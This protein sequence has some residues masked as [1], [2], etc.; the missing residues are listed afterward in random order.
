MFVKSLTASGSGEVQWRYF[1][2]RRHRCTSQLSS[3]GQLAS[4]SASTSS[5]WHTTVNSND[6]LW[7]FYFKCKID[8]VTSDCK[9]RNGWYLHPGIIHASRGVFRIAM[10]MSLQMIT[11]IYI[12]TAT[13][14]MRRFVSRLPS[15]L[16]KIQFVRVLWKCS[17]CIYRFLSLL[18][19]SMLA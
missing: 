2:I 9:G 11:K 8:S 16:I 15:C 5:R 6:D 3:R 18:K 13:R 19:T 7:G 14:A 10:P 12:N 1:L 17:P 4:P